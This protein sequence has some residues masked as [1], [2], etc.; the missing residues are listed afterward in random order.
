M[1]VTGGGDPVVIVTSSM[2]ALSA[3][4]TALTPFFLGRRRARKETLAAAIAGASDKADLTLAS[5]TALN[6]ALQ[7]E[8]TRLQ[9]VVDR[10]Q[11]TLDK[12][13]ARVDVLETELASLKAT[14]RNLRP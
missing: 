7:Q 6:G 13:Q 1:S 8:I 14:A 10:Q 12:C 2:L 5:W 4:G 3:L 11:G 9:G